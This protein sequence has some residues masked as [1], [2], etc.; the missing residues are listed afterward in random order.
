M[1]RVVACLRPTPPLAD[2]HL[3]LLIDEFSMVHKEIRSRN[4]PESFMKGWKAMLERGFFRCVLVGND[5]MPR[6]IQEFPNEFQVATE[7]RVSYL[8]RSYACKLIEDPIRLP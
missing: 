8:E 7:A 3:V 2:S 6:F 1:R 5:L 4:L